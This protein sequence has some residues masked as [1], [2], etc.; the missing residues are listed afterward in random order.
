MSRERTPED[1]TMVA[2]FARLN[3]VVRDL[4]RAIVANAPSPIRRLMAWAGG[5]HE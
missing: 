5:S 2:H 1:D 4:G 3:E